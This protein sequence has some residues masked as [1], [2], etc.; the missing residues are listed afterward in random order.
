MIWFLF[1]Y[2]H[3]S[4]HQIVVIV[5]DT[6][7][8]STARSV[9]RMDICEKHHFSGEKNVANSTGEISSFILFK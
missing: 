2:V 9:G 5:S 7:R 1:M 8:D 6:V 3:Y 4:G